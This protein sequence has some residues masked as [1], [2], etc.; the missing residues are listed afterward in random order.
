M[1]RS[2]PWAHHIVIPR[3]VNTF[4]APRPFRAGRACDAVGWRAIM[5]HFQRIESITPVNRLLPL[6]NKKRTLSAIPIRA[7]TWVIYSSPCPERARNRSTTAVPGMVL[8][9]YHPAPAIVAGTVRQRFPPAET[10]EKNSHW[11]CSR[12]RAQFL[13]K[14]RP[15]GPRR[16]IGNFME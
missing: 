8:L 3:Y 15:H 14:R 2:C 5:V 10:S 7:L 16:I 12:A 6:D 1:S 11:H 9:R 13:P 4:F